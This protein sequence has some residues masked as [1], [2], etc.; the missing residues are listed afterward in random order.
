MNCF[1][2]LNV[3]FQ[4]PLCFVTEGKKKLDFKCYI[5]SLTMTKRTFLATEKICGGHPH[6]LNL[7]C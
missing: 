5:N 1:N 3:F 7:I 2:F 4:Y 6:I